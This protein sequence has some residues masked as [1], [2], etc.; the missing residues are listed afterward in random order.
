MRPNLYEYNATTAVPGIFCSHCKAS[1]DTVFKYLTEDQ[2]LL[3]DI[4]VSKH[5]NDTFITPEIME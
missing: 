3:I 2:K 1:I 5:I 4:W